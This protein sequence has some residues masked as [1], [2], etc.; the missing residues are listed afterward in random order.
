MMNI[1]QI[2]EE[3][4]TNIILLDS[5]LG[6]AFGIVKIDKETFELREMFTSYIEDCL[7]EENKENYTL[8]IADVNDLERFDD[9]EYYSPV[10]H[11]VC[12]IKRFELFKGI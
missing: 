9:S 1:S 6:T 11:E 7:P 2:F 4:G 8:K 12:Y 3:H 10:L 5:D